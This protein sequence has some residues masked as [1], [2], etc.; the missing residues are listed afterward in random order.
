MGQGRLSWRRLIHYG[1]TSGLLYSDMGRMPPGLICDLYT[2]RLR[3]D[4]EE[5]GITRKKPRIYD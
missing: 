5:H 1:L 4:D 3:Y 2:M